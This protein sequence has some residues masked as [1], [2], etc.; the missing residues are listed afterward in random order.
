MT[1]G[2]KTSEFWVAMAVVVMGAVAQVYP[3]NQWS[4][5][6]GLIAGALASAGYGFARSRSKA[7]QSGAEASI[8]Q[9]KMWADGARKVDSDA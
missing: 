2:M 7:A 8:I 9:E 4:Q 3:G 5:M 6:A 1:A